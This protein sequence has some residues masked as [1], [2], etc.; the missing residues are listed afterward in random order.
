MPTAIAVI[1]AAKTVSW[2]GSG[3]RP[4]TVASVKVATRKE[5]Q[6]TAAIRAA[7]AAPTVTAPGR[8]PGAS[9]SSASRAALFFCSARAYPRCIGSL[10]LLR[11]RGCSATGRGL[12]AERAAQLAGDGV[13]AVG[14]TE[15]PHHAEPVGAGGDHLGGVAG[16][17][18][19]DREERQGRVG[20][21]VADQLQPG[22]RPSLF[23]RGGPDRADADVVD[24]LHRGRV[25]LLG[26]V[27]GEADQRVG[28]EDLASGGGGGVGLAQMDTV[29]V[30]GAGQV[31]VVV[32]D[33]QGAV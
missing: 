22:C 19:A 14:V 31:G 29:G 4:L 3:W 23:G 16:V 8:W 27:G 6:K 30:D 7:T 5:P 11:R 24:R 28:A 25:D 17:D 15:R 26:G 18:A 32:D 9:G 1:T 21:G 33:E 13:R 10:E 20:G 2:S 12:L